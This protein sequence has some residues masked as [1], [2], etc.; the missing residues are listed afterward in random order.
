M[1]KQDSVPHFVIDR[2]LTPEQITVQK[3]QINTKRCLEFIY[4]RFYKSEKNECKIFTKTLKKYGFE[5]STAA[6]VALQKVG[7]YIYS[8]WPSN[9]KENYIFTIEE[10]LP[11]ELDQRGLHLYHAGDVLYGQGFVDLSVDEFQDGDYYTITFQ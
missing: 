3:F 11:D 10:L 2:G 4:D 6:M 5:E 1:Q 9:Q 7:W 8:S